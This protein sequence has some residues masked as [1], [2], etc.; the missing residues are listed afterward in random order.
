MSVKFIFSNDINTLKDFFLQDFKIDNPFERNTIIV[1]NINVKKYLQLEIAKKFEICPD[2]NILYLE[3]GLFSILK[4][5]YDIHHRYIF[6]NNSDNIIYLQ[7]MIIV[8][9]FEIIENYNIKDSYLLLFKNYLKEKE[10]IHKIIWELSEKITFYFR[11]YQYQR[12]ELVEKWEEDCIYFNDND[13]EKFEKFIYQ[14]L[15]CGENSLI[16]KLSS[17]DIIYTTLPLFIKELDFK[18]K[19]D[20]CGKIYLFGLSQ[21]SKFHYELIN[22]L[23]NIYEFKIFQLNYQDIDTHFNLN[24]KNEFIKK[25]CLAIEKN[26]KIIPNS[27][28]NSED[29]IINN[30]NFKGDRLLNL[31]KRS[32]FEKVE[33]I[34]KQDKSIQIIGCPLKRR[35]VEVVYDSIITNMLENKEL[36]LTDIAIL[37]TDIENYKYEIKSIFDSYDIIKYNLNDFTLGIESNLNKAILTFLELMGSNYEKE[38]VVELI[39]NPLVI[40]KFRLTQSEINDF[41]F[42]I[43]QLDIYFSYN[44]KDKEKYSF[45]KTPLFTWEYG[46]KRTRIG[47]LIGKEDIFKDGISPYTNSYLKEIENLDKFNVILET[48]FE[49]INFIPDI[50]A[51]QWKEKIIDFLNTFIEISEDD[52]LEENVKDNLFYLLDSLEKFDNILN[53]N[54]NIEYIK[55]YIKNNLTQIELK[56]GSFLSDGVTISKLLPMKPIPFKIMYIIGLNEDTF[57]QYKDQSSLDLRNYFSDY[58]SKTEVD[59]YLFLETI[60]SCQEKLYLTYTSRDL[61]KDAILYPSSVIRDLVSYINENLLNTNFEIFEATINI[62]DDK[63][64]DNNN[65]YNDIYQCNINEKIEFKNSISF[66]ENNK[67]IDNIRFKS[68]TQDSEEIILNIVDLKNYLFDPKK[69]LLKNKL[70]VDLERFPKKGIEDIETFYFDINNY[71]FSKKKIFLDLLF[72]NK[73]KKLIEIK[74]S[75]EDFYK[76]FVIEKLEKIKNGLDNIKEKILETNIN[77]NNTLFS[78]KNYY[79]VIKIGFFK[80]N[81]LTIF[82]PYSINNLYVIGEIN[83]I[84]I[85]DNNVYFFD[86]YDSNVLN[87]KKVIINKDLRK[88]IYNT[89]LLTALLNKKRKD[90]LIYNYIVIQ[91][92]NSILFNLESKEIS[93]YFDNVLEDYVEDLKNTK[94]IIDLDFSILCNENIDFK[95]YLNNVYMDY[96]YERNDYFTIKDQDI[97]LKYKNLN[98]TEEIFNKIYQR[99]YNIINK[100]KISE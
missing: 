32:L 8:I 20:I 9:L 68:F 39:K 92:D 2:L 62:D 60:L 3:S 57:P 87:R 55:K 65:D 10:N 33:K 40:K 94:E 38:K 83:D 15:F 18:I 56:K 84:F 45:F 23:S 14:R 81:N 26:I 24:S 67:D 19:K 41:I 98:L 96:S 50:S 76:D 53:K 44:K 5:L 82:E 80:P 64:F 74:K 78:E 42:T 90:E 69:V 37:V 93:S 72:N 85:N 63:N 30:R 17:Q 7:L 29:I 86:I 1:P 73:E 89:L 100:L 54:I 59:N 4:E 48:L 36:K 49:K 35:E 12:K 99:R 97:L 11:E 70:K 21:I 47:Y 27:I 61:E 31:F 66:L 79:E 25:Y 71:T 91:H 43:G 75:I 95:S 77:Y 34:E 13:I 88:D 51:K 6:L 52:Y 22:K 16:K 46:L 28:K 58:I